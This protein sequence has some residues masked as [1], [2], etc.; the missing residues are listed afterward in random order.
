M[1]CKEQEKGW[2]HKKLNPQAF[3]YIYT[4]SCPIKRTKD[5]KGKKTVLTVI[6]D[7]YH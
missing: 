2:D 6:L 7:I 5:P 3:L 4:Y 1:K